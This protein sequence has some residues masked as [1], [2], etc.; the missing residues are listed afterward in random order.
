MFLAVVIGQVVATKKDESM[1]GRKLLLL[2][3]QLVDEANPTKFRNG[4]NTIVAVDTVGAGEGELVM[5]CQGSSARQAGG[6]RSIPV[7]AAVVAIVDTVD[8]LGK[9]IYGS[10]H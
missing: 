2:R 10:S 4:A 3:P 9:K 6:L 7:D 1:K 5:F 8:V